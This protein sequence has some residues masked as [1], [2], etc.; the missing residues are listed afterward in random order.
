ME[1]R[2]YQRIDMDSLNAD[3]SDGKGMYTGKVENISRSGISVTDLPLDMDS[4]SDIITAIIS[5]EGEHF[6]M[7]L[8]PRWD[9]VEGENKSIGLEIE[10]C[11]WGWSE[12]VV[13]FEPKEDAPLF[14]SAVH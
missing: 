7:F 11:S 9:I 13:Q 14:S 4:K 1:N 8:K 3:I 2:K 6:K 5:G 10:S 12:F